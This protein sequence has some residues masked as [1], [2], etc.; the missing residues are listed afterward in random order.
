MSKISKYD[1]IVIGGGH[2]GL[3]AAAYLG[4]AGKKVLVLERRHVLGG[5]GAIEAVASIKTLQNKAIHPT[6]NYRNPDPL[7]DLDYVPNVARKVNVK[8]VLSNNFG[9]GG[10]NACI[11]F[12]NGH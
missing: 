7:C 10:Q 3:T 4:L 5:A 11:V 9:F 6:I 12:G 1:A 2:N 8:K